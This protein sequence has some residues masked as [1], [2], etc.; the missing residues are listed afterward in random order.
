MKK[1]VFLAIATLSLS[2]IFCTTQQAGQASPTPDINAMVSA[3][4]TAAAIVPSL[5]VATIPPVPTILT[6]PATGSISGHLSYPSDF[7]PPLRVVAFDAANTSIFYYVDTGQN[8]SSYTITGVT[9]GTYH[10]VSYGIDAP[11]L[12][13]GYTQMV[14]CGLAADCSDHSFID[15]T[16]TPGATITGIDPGDWYANEGTFPPMPTP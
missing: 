13:G 12:A 7:I 3:T 11:S 10:V 8:Q 15:V 1:G 2:A 4:L 9:A 6:V 14:P 5:T 16:I